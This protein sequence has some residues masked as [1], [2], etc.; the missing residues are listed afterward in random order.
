MRP[1]GGR[2]RAEMK[3][4]AV[5]VPPLPK[6]SIMLISSIFLLRILLIFHQ[7]Q[8][9]A[10]P[11]TSK[12]RKE[13]V[14]DKVAQTEKVVAKSWVKREKAKRAKSVEVNSPSN[15]DKDPLLSTEEA[16]LSLYSSDFRPIGV[17]P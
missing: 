7:T 17:S 10:K 9:H 12:K 11:K 2:I 6:I 5:G 15:Q 4:K 14:A 13:R 1:E 3:A 16:I 8:D